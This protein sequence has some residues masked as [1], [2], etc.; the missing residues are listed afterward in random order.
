MVRQP[1]YR[2]IVWEV[3]AH[4]WAEPHPPLEAT[5][6]NTIRTLHHA[7][8]AYKV[9]DL[10]R[11]GLGTYVDGVGTVT[12]VTPDGNGGQIETVQMTHRVAVFQPTGFAVPLEASI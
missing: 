4:R 5:M 10:I 9:G 11:F 1:N 6:P 2:C 7:E 8:G 12:A 3:P